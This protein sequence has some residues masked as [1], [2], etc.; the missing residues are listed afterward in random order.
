MPKPTIEELEA[1]FA[2]TADGIELAVKDLQEKKAGTQEVLDLID[3]KTAADKELLTKAQ[4][5]VEELNSGIGE[6]NE[7]IKQIQSKLG[8]IRQMSA[9]DLAVNG[10]YKGLFASPQEAKAFAL[11]VMAATTAGDQKFASVHD[12][13]KKSLDEMGIDPYLVDEAGRK[14]MTGGSVTGGGSLVTSE[15][16]PS[17]IYLLE[18]YGRYRANAQLMPM[19]AGQTTQPK[20]D[21]L[22]TM[23]VPGEGGE[24]TKGDPTIKLV[25]LTPKTLCGLTAY[26]LELEDDSLVMLGEMLGGLFARSIAYYEDLCGFLGDGTSTYFGFSGIAGALRAV[27]ATIGNIKS[28]VVG[29]GNAY[30]ELT[31]ANF[32]SVAGTLPNFAD[33]DDTAGGVDSAKWYVHRYFYWTVMVKLALAAGSGT[34]QEVLLGTAVRQKSYLSYPV[35]FTQVMPKAEGNSQICAL[36]GNLRQ[37]AYLGTRG[38]IEVAQ[39]EHR[40]FDQGLMAVRVRSRMAINVHGVGDTTNAGPICGLITAGS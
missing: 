9:S 19:G 10:R 32:E 20:I 7:A 40:Y 12:S 22:M 25:S 37:G 6:V 33:S 14:T 36:L 1:R 23:Y 30:S 31:L 34:A 4:A 15:Q 3:E 2:K 13:A 16:I 29:A 18:R 24:I 21:G 26:S 38:G 39:S 8:R 17:I 35:E 28:L 5:D 27:D 11:L